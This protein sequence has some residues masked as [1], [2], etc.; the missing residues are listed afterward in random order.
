[1]NIAILGAGAMGS[2][3]GGLLAEAG[4]DVILLD[5]N[6]AHLNAIREHGLGVHTDSGDRR[7]RQ[8]TAIRPEQADKSPDLLIVFTK[9]L[10]TEAALAGVRRL[11][12]PETLVLTLQNGLGNIEAV[13]R[14]VRQNRILIGMTTWPAD[15]V[16]PGQVHSHG[17]GLVRIMPVE[18]QQ[19]KAAARVAE[20]L[21][22]AGLRCEVD[23]QAWAAIWEKVAFNAAL[24]SLCAV[25]GCTVGQLNAIP[26]GP[27]LARAVVAEV[28]ATAQS[29]GVNADT[30][31][32]MAS[33]ADALAKHKTHKPSMLQDVLAG[34]QTEIESINGEVVARAHRAGIAVPHTEMLLGLVR[35]IQ[36]RKAEDA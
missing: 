34:R 9:T 16:G 3:F 13:S 10:H 7:I 36:A 30:A 33:V 22:L 19:Q 11:L 6:D 17:K 31:H 28:I 15:L 24:N 2:L 12:S 29:A 5:I 18:I 32:C 1:M 14:H 26:D 25:T 20:I 8:L 23:P 35:L 4:Q 27:A 21:N